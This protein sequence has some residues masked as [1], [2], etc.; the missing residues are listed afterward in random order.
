MPSH[1]YQ[2]IP[3]ALAASPAEVFRTKEES[4]KGL[5]FQIGYT[6]Y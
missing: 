2:Q 3:T 1:R 6:I 5:L 4:K